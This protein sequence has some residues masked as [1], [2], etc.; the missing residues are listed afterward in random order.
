MAGIGFISTA[1]CVVVVTDSGINAGAFNN[2]GSTKIARAQSIAFTNRLPFVHLVESAG[3]NIPAYR[4][5]NFVSGG[6]LFAG[7]ARLSAAG[8]PVITVLHGSSRLVGHTCLAC[9]TW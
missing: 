8:I 3:A 9:P 2:A 7:L 5:E 4:V 1:R 6:Q